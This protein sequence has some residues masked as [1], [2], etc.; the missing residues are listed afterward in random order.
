MVGCVRIGVA[1]ALICGT[2]GAVPSRRTVRAFDAADALPA[3]STAFT[4]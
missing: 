3:P 4:V 1:A 2:L